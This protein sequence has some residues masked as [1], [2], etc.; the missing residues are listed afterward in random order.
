M[1]LIARPAVGVG[2]NTVPLEKGT[3]T[4]GF[5]EGEQVVNRWKQ[6]RPPREG[7]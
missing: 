1:A 6:H 7:D 4:G 2:S 3:E 5:G